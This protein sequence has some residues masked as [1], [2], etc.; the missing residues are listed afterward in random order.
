MAKIRIY[1]NFQPGT[2]TLKDFIKELQVKLAE[3]PEDYKDIA[4]ITFDT[5]SAY[6]DYYPTAEIAYFREETD[7]DAEAAERIELDKRQE[8]N[9]RIREL[10]LLEQLKRKYAD[11]VG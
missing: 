5:D 9:I 4:Y 6:G 1:K 2:S 3:I 8:E 7:A 10:K 11:G